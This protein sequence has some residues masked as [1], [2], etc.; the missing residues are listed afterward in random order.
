MAKE[1]KKSTA[2]PKAKAKQGPH[3][4]MTLVQLSPRERYSKQTTKNTK[5]PSRR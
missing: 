2:K 4:T 3:K 5:G 1:L